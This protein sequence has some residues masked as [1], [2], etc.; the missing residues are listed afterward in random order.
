MEL[1]RRDW[2][3]GVGMGL[4]SAVMGTNPLSVVSHSTQTVE[5]TDILR[6][7]FFDALEHWMVI[8]ERMPIHEMYDLLLPPSNSSLYQDELAR[9]M[10]LQTAGVQTLRNL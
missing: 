2:L 3:G 5:A 7:M 6:K 4:A 8:F 10:G 1:N 9:F